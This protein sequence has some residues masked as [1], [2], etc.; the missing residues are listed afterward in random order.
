MLSGKTATGFKFEIDEEAR[1][2]MELLDM[3]SALDDGK[4]QYV[5]KVALVLLGKEQ[6]EALYEHCRNEKGRVSA[7]EVIKEMYS[8]FNVIGNGESDTKN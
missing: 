3:I 5:P 1:D 2:D 4:L 7:R 8:I 6:K